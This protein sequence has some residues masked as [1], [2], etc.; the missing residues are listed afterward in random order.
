MGESTIKKSLRHRRK[1]HNKNNRKN[2]RKHYRS[3][4]DRTERIFMAILRL[5]AENRKM[6]VRSIARAAGISRYTFYLRYHNYQHAVAKYRDG[7]VDEC[8]G[9]VAAVARIGEGNERMDGLALSVLERTKLKVVGDSNKR[10]VMAVIMH[11]SSH[12]EIYTLATAC[13]I[14][15]E[16]ICMIGEGLANKLK[17]AWRPDIPKRDS[18]EMRLFIAELTEI[19]MV[20]ARCTKCNEAQAEGYV[21]KIMKLVNNPGRCCG[22]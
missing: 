10:M 14:N 1:E 12:A 16:L 11:L 9:K 4:Q 17:P 8:M 7:L 2:S 5:R 18:M 13:H 15:R 22:Y 3:V 21:N 6:T 20:W 19:L